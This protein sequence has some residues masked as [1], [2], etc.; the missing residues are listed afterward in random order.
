MTTTHR[1]EAVTDSPAGIYLTICN[2][3][4]VTRVQRIQA[5]NDV[6]YVKHLGCLV[7]CILMLFLEVRTPGAIPRET[8]PSLAHRLDE[9]D[10]G[11]GLEHDQGPDGRQAPPF[12]HRVVHD[13]QHSEQK[14]RDNKQRVFSSIGN[15][16]IVSVHAHRRTS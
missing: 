8:F 14:G 12:S 7:I 9:R 1:F 16:L 3:G 11:H 4:R 13:R 10:R 5:S 6:H 15:R 2:E